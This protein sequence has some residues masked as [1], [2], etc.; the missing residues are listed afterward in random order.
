MPWYSGFGRTSS[1]AGVRLNIC[2]SSMVGGR[3]DLCSIGNSER[4]SGEEEDRPSEISGLASTA[5]AS[6]GTSA[7]SALSSGLTSV[8]TSD[9]STVL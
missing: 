7:S 1:A 2:W 9:S 8:G 5:S 6:V 4:Y 3:L